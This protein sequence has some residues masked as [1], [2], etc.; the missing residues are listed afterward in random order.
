MFYR[1]EQE[2][3]QWHHAYPDSDIQEWSQLDI[4]LDHIVDSQPFYDE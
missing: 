3:L 1:G 2:F 4:A